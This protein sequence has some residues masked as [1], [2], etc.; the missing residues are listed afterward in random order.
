MRSRLNVLNHHVVKGGVSLC[1]RPNWQTIG[2]FVITIVDSTVK[3]IVAF[4]GL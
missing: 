2:I 3:Y 4:G 1:G